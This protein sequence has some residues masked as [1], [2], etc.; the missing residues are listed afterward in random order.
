MNPHCLNRAIERICRDYNAQEEELA[1]KE[2][3]EPLLLPHFS[4]H[5][6]RHTFCTRL[7][8]VEPDCKFIQQ[9]MGHADISTT[10][11]IYTH[12]T[13]EKMKSTVQSISKNLSLF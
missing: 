1:V 10:M 12:I 6:L 2:D 9:V 11:D 8:E 5:N 13:Q 7:F 3:R 4:V